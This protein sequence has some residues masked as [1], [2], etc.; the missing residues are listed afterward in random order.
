VAAHGRMMDAIKILQ[1]CQSSI[2]A[3]LSFNQTLPQLVRQ[4]NEG[5]AD[6]EVLKRSG[7]P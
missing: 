1:S 2:L 5:Y 3:S 7:S 4:V 6:T